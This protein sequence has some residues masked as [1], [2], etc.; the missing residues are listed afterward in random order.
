MHFRSRYLLTEDLRPVYCTS[1]S[2][3][4]T[5]CVP[6]YAANFEKVMDCFK[7]GGPSGLSAQNQKPIFFNISWKVLLSNF[8]LFV[9]LPSH[10]GDSE[11]ITFTCTPGEIDNN[12]LY[13]GYG[14]HTIRTDHLIK[15]EIPTWVC[16]IGLSIQL[17]II[18][19]NWD[20]IS[21]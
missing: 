7:K 8:S 6:L 10:K 17:K 11:S 20:E 3:V 21:T 15:N 1:S 18:I 2:V 16:C 12:S 14:E 9:N 13:D 19:L 4:W 5:G